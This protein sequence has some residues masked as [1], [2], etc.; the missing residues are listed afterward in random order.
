MYLSAIMIFL[1]AVVGSEAVVCQPP[2]VLM[3]MDI[4]VAMDEFLANLPE[5]QPPRNRYTGCT[6]SLSCEQ[7]DI[8]HCCC[9]FS[10]PPGPQCVHSRAECTQGRRG[11]RRRCL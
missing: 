8:G 10:F 7:R 9:N 1:V 2:V 11:R 3:D 4:L 6:T 5:T